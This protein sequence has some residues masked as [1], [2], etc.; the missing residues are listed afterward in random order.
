M[1]HLDYDALPL[2]S[3]HGQMLMVDETFTITIK[4]DIEGV[5]GSTLLG[6]VINILEKHKN[7][8]FVGEG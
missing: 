3:Y 7:A 8:L 1:Y 4:L 6:E 5:Q 2:G